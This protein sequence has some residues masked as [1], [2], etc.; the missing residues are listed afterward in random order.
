LSITI[1]GRIG[2]LVKFSKSITLAVNNLA[3]SNVSNISNITNPQSDVL[4]VSQN[5]HNSSKGSNFKFYI[6]VE[7]N[8]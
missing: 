6:S 2:Y 7:E 1:A 4:N 8:A 3:L 5:H